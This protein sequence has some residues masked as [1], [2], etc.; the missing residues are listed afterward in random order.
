MIEIQKNPARNKRT[1]SKS[2]SAKSSKGVTI[3]QASEQ[4]QFVSADERHCMIAEAAYYLAVQRNFQGN[5]ALEDWL[6]AEVDVDAQLA[7]NEARL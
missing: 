3:A 7:G 6:R 1:V 2:R 5:N 4:A